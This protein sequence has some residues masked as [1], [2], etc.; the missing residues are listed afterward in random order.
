MTSDHAE[1]HDGLDPDE[2]NTPLWVTALGATLF[3]L[4]GIFFLVT[5]EPDAPQA[6]AAAQPTAEAPAVPAEE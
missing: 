5:S 6:K 1:P 4:A 3:L 2:P